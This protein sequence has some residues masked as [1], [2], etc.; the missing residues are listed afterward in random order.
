MAVEIEASA[1][2]F[3]AE[4][5][6]EIFVM[7]K[8]HVAQAVQNREPVVERERS[9]TANRARTRIQTCVRA[10]AKGPIWLQ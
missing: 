9:V 10:H 5:C 1:F 7:V 8:L 3:G 4:V 6:C 2:V